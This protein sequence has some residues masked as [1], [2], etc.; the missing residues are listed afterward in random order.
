MAGSPGA[1]H[2]PGTAL[3]T[4]TVLPTGTGDLPPETLPPGALTDARHA[5]AVADALVASGSFTAR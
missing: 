3:P 2:P 1:G 4:G 5:R